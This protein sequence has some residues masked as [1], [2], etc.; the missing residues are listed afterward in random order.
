LTPDDQIDTG[1]FGP[2]DG[3]TPTDWPDGPI[4]P[5]PWT[6]DSGDSLTAALLS[7]LTGR[8]AATLREVRDMVRPYARAALVADTSPGD[9]TDA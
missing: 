4:E 2:R 3:F 7:L 8:D 9:S 1:G 6:P 5:T